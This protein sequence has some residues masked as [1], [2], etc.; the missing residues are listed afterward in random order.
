MLSIGKRPVYDPDG[1][2]EPGQCQPYHRTWCLRHIERGRETFLYE[3]T[4][5]ACREIQ[6]RCAGRPAEVLPKVVEAVKAEFEQDMQETVAMEDTAVDIETPDD[7]G[8]GSEPDTVRLERD[9]VRPRIK[10]RRSDFSF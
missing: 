10:R 4:Y 1:L 6:I 5:Y 3:G 7:A 9:R 2:P 8:R